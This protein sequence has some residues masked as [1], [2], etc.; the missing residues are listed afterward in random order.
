MHGYVYSRSIMNCTVHATH[1]GVGI[2]YKKLGVQPGLT[3]HVMGGGRFF[4]SVSRKVG[5]YSQLA[6]IR[7]TIPALAAERLSGFY[8]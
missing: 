1:A 2:D 3:Y 6:D 4:P 8:S 5:P 7:V